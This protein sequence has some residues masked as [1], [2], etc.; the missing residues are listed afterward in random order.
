MAIKKEG[1]VRKTEI[2]D[3]AESLFYSKGYNNTTMN[4]ILNKTGIAKGTLYYYFKSKE[5]ILDTIIMRIIENDIINSKKIANDVNLSPVEK[6][7]TILINQRPEN[8]KDKEKIYDQICKPE[9]WELQQKTWA[10]SIKY[11]SPI[12]ASVVEEGIEK[13][14][15][16]TPYPLEIVELL[17]ATGNTLFDTTLFNWNEEELEK[18]LKVFIFSIEKLLGAKEGT[19]IN[20]RKVIL[21]KNKNV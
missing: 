20:A 13:K 6:I 5:E 19:F 8:V 14:L 15:F 7:Y 11:L 12:I 9:N 17:L 16:F 4:D 18:R 10:L 2:L 3:I 1:Q 21:W